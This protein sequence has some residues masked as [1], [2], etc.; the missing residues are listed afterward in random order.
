MIGE[1]AGREGYREDV[2]FVLAG[3]ELAFCIA[4]ELERGSLNGCG[5]GV[6]DL[7]AFQ[8]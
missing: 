3:F 2:S 8:T 5:G 6:D 7:V 1:G 4:D